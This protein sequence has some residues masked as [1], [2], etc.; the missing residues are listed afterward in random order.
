VE[1]DTL[2]DLVSS[3]VKKVLPEAF[4]SDLRCPGTLSAPLKALLCLDK[5]SALPS[6]RKLPSI[7]VACYVLVKYVT[8][9]ASGQ[10]LGELWSEQTVS[11]P[12]AVTGI[13]V[14]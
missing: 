4:A 11:H 12:F 6:Q 10:C 13:S 5:K 14:L 8:S 7:S 1:Q 9:G 3:A 2:Q